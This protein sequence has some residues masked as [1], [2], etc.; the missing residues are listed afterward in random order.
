MNI[1]KSFIVI[2]LTILTFNIYPSYANDRGIEGIGGSLRVISGEH[3]DI[4]MIKEKI[5]MDINEKT[6]SVKVDFTFKNF[7]K[8]TVN[9]KMGFPESGHGDVDSQEKQQKS[10][11]ISFNSF[12][13]K[14]PI[15][16]N[17]KILSTDEMGYKAYWIKDVTFKP[18]EE[19]QI[20]VN[21][22]SKLGNIALPGIFAEYE[23]TGGNWKGKV[24]DSTF[25]AKFKLPEYY[26]VYFDEYG[27]PRDVI[28]KGN[29]LIFNRKNWEAEY[30][31]PIMF[32]RK[33]F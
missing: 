8:K 10:G 25:I 32:I 33:K 27:T 20:Q 2:I 11:F 23:F 17:R 19:L 15:R 6:Y 16:V 14:K 1:K 26:S 31:L 28:Q 21:Y 4:S 18:L 13:N 3:K 7:S 29:T 24:Q 5:F 9:V 30:Y 12:I 22:V